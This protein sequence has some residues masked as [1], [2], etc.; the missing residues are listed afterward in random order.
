MT[1][2]V[3]MQRPRRRLSF[4]QR[5]LW[6]F[7]AALI[8][9]ALVLA[10]LYSQSFSLAQFSDAPATT[11]DAVIPLPPTAMSPTTEAAVAGGSS[12]LFDAPVPAAETATPTEAQIAAPQELFPTTDSATPT[13]AL[14]T[15]TVM[16]VA[17]LN[18]RPEL[19]R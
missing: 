13:T 1:K 12:W 9:M 19:L 15:V 11:E 18:E 10:F 3:T 14:P 6:V 17:A 5:T 4:W 7:V 16:E 2:Y 8:V